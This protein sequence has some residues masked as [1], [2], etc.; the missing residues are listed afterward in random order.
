M[1]SIHYC[2]DDIKEDADADEESRLMMRNLALAKLYYE[3]MLLQC[4]LCTDVV[5]LH[6]QRGNEYSDLARLLPA[7]LAQVIESN[8]SDKT[9]LLY[10]DLKYCHFHRCIRLHDSA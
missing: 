7:C 4:S 3:A 6:W 10:K 2:R 5:K 8:P 9:H 1:Q